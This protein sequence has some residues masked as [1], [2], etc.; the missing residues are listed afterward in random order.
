[1]SANWISGNH[2][3][4]LRRRPASR[5]PMPM[6]R[7][8]ARRM[9]FEK[10]ASSRTYAGIHRISAISRKRTRKDETKSDIAP[11]L[12]LESGVGLLLVA[13]GW[14]LVAGKSKGRW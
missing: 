5:Q 8:L 7:K 10:Y 3:N 13:S 11:A 9:K 6:P 4:R 1:M 12:L 2:A 14:L